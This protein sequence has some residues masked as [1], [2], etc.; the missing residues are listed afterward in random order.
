[1]Q[2]ELHAKTKVSEF[3]RGVKKVLGAVYL[4]KSELETRKHI[5]MHWL[6]ASLL[7]KNLTWIA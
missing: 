3:K 5:K 1:M 6:A 4:L 7:A 2:K